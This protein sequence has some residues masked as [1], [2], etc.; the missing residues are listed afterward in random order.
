MAQWP[1]Q[2][3]P[4]PPTHS[5]THSHR[6]YL[7]APV[8]V[9]SAIVDDVY[10]RHGSLAGDAADTQDRSAPRRSI[11]RQET[12]ETFCR[13]WSNYV[14][15]SHVIVVRPRRPAILPHFFPPGPGPHTESGRRNISM[16]NWPLSVICDT[17]RTTAQQPC[18][19]WLFLFIC[20]IAIE[21]HGQ[22]IK[23]PVLWSP[24]LCLSVCTLTVADNVFED[25]P[26]KLFFHSV[27]NCTGKYV[28]IH[29]MPSTVTASRN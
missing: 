19:I 26:V 13:D 16:T 25:L 6:L 22:I 24:H 3:Y 8:T 21:Q 17:N 29:C 1:V 20:S 23:S 15:P 2:I 12:A 5:L 9:V 27:R 28:C 4:S 11:N 10:R 14:T 7:L 18:H